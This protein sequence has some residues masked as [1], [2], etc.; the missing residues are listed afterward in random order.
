MVHLSALT[1]IRFVV[2]I[3]IGLL[4]Y[5]LYGIHHSKEDTF[6]TSYSILMTAAKSKPPYWKAT[7]VAKD[8]LGKIMDKVKNSRS[9]SHGDKKPIIITDEQS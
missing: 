2:W 4:V 5:F 3:S 1:W 6:G 7:N 9:D 8:T